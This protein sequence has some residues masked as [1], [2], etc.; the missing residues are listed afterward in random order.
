M[1]G[2]AKNIVTFGGLSVKTW[3]KNSYPW[4]VMVIVCLV[5][6]FKGFYI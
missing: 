3:V 5:V 4:V 6:H 2:I 1:Q